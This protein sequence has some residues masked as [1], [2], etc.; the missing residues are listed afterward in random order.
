MEISLGPLTF[1]IFVGLTA[2]ILVSIF[3][4]SKAKKK[5]IRAHKI[6]LKEQVVAHHNALVRSIS[7]HQ[8][9]NDFGVILKDKSNLAI[10]EFLRSVGWNK[11][12]I[13][14]MSA[15]KI[16]RDHLARIKD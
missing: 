5:K 8:K 16:V 1:A 12:L 3:P 11:K 6:H 14:R 13:D 7:K 15:R 10:D 2:G 4:K 9:V